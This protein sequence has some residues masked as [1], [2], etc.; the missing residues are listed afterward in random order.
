MTPP[1]DLRTAA[2]TVLRRLQTS[3]HTAYF[4][5]GCV[6][7]HLRGVTPKDYDIATSATPDEVEALFH[8]R[9]DLVGKSF[10]VVIVRQDGVHV[11]VATFRR[12]GPYHDG[13]RPASVEFTSAE[14]DARRRDFTV[15][16]LFWNPLTD[17][18]L[19]F[20]GGRE[21]LAAKRL[22]AVGNARDR[23]TEDKLR[24]LRAVRFASNLGFEI[25]PATWSALC[26]L[27]PEITRVAPERIREELTRWLTGPHPERGL[28]LLDNSGLLAR[29]LPEVA[30]QKGVDQPPQFHPEGD[31]YVHVRLMLSHLREPSAVL[32][33]SVLL[34][35][36]GKPPTRSVDATGRIRFNGHEVVG[37]RMARALLERLRFSNADIDAICACVANHMAFKDAPHMRLSTLKRFLNRPTFPDELALHRIDC[38]SSHGDLSIHTFLN[39]QLATLPPEEIA[40]PPLIT[41]HDVIALGMKP[42]P[43]LGAVVKEAYQMQLE[44]AF[45]G[46]EPALHWLRAR[47][48]PG[49]G[50]HGPA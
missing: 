32:A 50:N 20:V 24:L 28:D 5:G 4:A 45:D 14:E 11:E 42:G 6:R 12:D 30:A 23:F 26:E 46:R 27:A 48:A 33:W 2:S 22:C 34:H 39:D 40:P 8:G 15:N 44:G 21:D 1:A 47:L 38:L 13:R 18:I 37:A 17:E 10:G 36:I 29:L 9:S 43:A 3:G 49:G 16:A 19:D 7:D 25:E 31:V 35:D 41:G